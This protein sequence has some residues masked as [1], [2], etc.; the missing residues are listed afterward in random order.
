MG[1]FELLTGIFDQVKGEGR[2]GGDVEVVRPGSEEEG[3]VDGLGE[4][5]RVRM[6]MY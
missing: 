6:S 1:E 2:V 3:V 5:E 4:G